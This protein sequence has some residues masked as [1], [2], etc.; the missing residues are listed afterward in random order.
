[1]HSDCQ[2]HTVSNSLIYTH[3]YTNTHTQFF[4]QLQESQHE[5]HTHTHIHTHT[6]SACANYRSHRMRHTHTHTHAHTHTFDLHTQS[7]SPIFAARGWYLI[8][9]SVRAMPI[10]CVQVEIT[11]CL[12]DTSLRP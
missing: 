10:H 9:V 2:I 12:Q 5:T 11:T 4:G 3:T 1:G 6:H 7:S 8:S